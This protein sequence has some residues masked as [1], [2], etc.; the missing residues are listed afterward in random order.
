MCAKLCIYACTYIHDW[1]MVFCVCCRGGKAV[2]NDGM[3]VTVTHCVSD[4]MG[5]VV[6]VS[7]EVVEVTVDVTG[8]AVVEMG[9]AV[10][11]IGVV[12]L[13]KGVAVLECCVCWLAEQCVE[14]ELRD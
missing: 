10:V 5:V 1:V 4:E 3:R 9:V 2:E 11:V 8:V 12:V 13:V 14:R 7:G 6:V